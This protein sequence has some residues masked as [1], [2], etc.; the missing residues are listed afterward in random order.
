LVA[1]F[2]LPQGES[3]AN[4][5]IQDLEKYFMKLP[6]AIRSGNTSEVFRAVKAWTDLSTGNLAEMFLV[7]RPMVSRFLSGSA[8][9]SM[10]PDAFR[11]QAL[12]I[13]MTFAL[14]EPVEEIGP[15]VFYTDMRPRRRNGSRIIATTAM[16]AA[17]RKRLEARGVII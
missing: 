15:N 1:F 2:I 11:I 3:M 17:S 5:S 6:R 14:R 16:L 13:C 9:D 4:E 7:S 8:G 10:P 12:N